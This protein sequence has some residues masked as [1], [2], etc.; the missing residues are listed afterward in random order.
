MIEKSNNRQITAF[1]NNARKFDNGAMNDKLLRHYSLNRYG[2]K[3]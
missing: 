3:S 1:Q 2:Y